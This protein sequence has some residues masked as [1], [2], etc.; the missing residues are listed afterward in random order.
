MSVGL[1]ALRGLESTLLVHVLTRRRQIETAD[2]VAVSL[3]VVHGL[4]VV[5]SRES[6]YLVATRSIS[7]ISNMV[8]APVLLQVQPQASRAW[9]VVVAAL[10]AL[11]EGAS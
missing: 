10:D 9:V 4:L 2:I 6:G 1:L 11:G 7:N 5:V 8:H 3:V